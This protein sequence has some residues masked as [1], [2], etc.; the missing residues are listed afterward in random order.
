MLVSLSFLKKSYSIKTLIKKSDFFH[1]LE[2]LWSIKEKAD[3]TFVRIMHNNKLSYPNKT[4]YYNDIHKT[5]WLKT[6]KL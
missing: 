4:I 5:L 2:K 1:Y 6:R 3:S